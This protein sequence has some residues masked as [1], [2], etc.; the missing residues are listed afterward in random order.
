MS[1]NPSCCLVTFSHRWGCSLYISITVKYVFKFGLQNRTHFLSSTDLPAASATTTL[2]E[3]FSFNVTFN[4]LNISFSLPHK[5]HLRTISQ[6]FHC[7][8]P[9]SQV[10]PS[11]F[12]PLLFSCPTTTLP[13]L[14]L[15]LSPHLSCHPV[16]FP[17]TPPLPVASSE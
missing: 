14:A 4:M 9:L 13:T 7:H 11:A 3:L 5:Q 12:F 15:I 2:S 10:L 1:P 6:P 17:F 8:F 16:P